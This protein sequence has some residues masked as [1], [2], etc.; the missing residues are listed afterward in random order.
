MSENRSG[1]ETNLI[2]G[3][4]SKARFSCLVVTAGGGESVVSETYITLTLT[5]L[6]YVCINHGEQ[7]FIQIWNNHKFLS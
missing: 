4:W 7:R 2:G 6:K 5:T 3:M 1:L